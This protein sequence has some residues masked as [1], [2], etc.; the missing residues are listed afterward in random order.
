MIDKRLQASLNL[1]V[2]LSDEG[3]FARGIND[4]EAQIGFIGEVETDG[5]MCKVRAMQG[6]LRIL[7]KK[8]LVVGPFSWH[9]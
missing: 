2:K 9:L 3:R 7:F 5:R 4:A 6:P 8:L 1:R